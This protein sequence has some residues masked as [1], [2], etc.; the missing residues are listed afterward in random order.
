M[1]CGCPLYKKV[2][3]L[4]TI[5]IFRLYLLKINSLKK[6]KMKKYTDICS[7][8][9]VIKMRFSL[10]F[11]TCLYFT[12]IYAQDGFEKNIEVIKKISLENSFTKATSV[13][14]DG[15]GRLIS[16]NVK[17]ANVKVHDKNGQLLVNY[18]RSGRGP[19]DFMYPLSTIRLTS[20]RLLTIEFHGKISIFNETADSLID[21]HNVEILPLSEV[22]EI[23]E[24]R[25][26]LVGS[27]RIGDQVKLLHVFDLSTGRILKS[28]LNLPFNLSDYGGIFNSISKL[29]A[30]DV[31]DGYIASII[32]PF[33]EIIFFDTD[34]SIVRRQEI[35]INNFKKIEQ[36]NGELNPRNAA[37]YITTFSLAE[38]I[39]WLDED[40][41]LVNFYRIT[42][43]EPSSRDKNLIQEFA[44]AKIDSSGKVQF[45]IGKTPNLKAVRR[46]KLYFENLNLENEVEILVAKVV[47]Q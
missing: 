26:L 39:F 44:L 8:K 32:T 34:G 40:N 43:F 18:G 45:E 23:D 22:H 17:Q 19:G 5:H 47:N 7:L 33:P 38:N 1:N 31:K 10:I 4:Y 15:Q 16:T 20:G 41:I 28:F 30:A 37:E 3:C 11:I 2:R 27:K 12:N 35:E 13:T 24:N 46:N 42:N 9:K 36:Q 25:I 29:A 14:I 6:I 21:I